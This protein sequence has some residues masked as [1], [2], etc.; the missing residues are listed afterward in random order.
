MVRKWLDLVKCRVI[1]WIILESGVPLH[2]CEMPGNV[3]V[4]VLED[5]RNKFWWD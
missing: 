5:N 3:Y 4:D 2:I 1:F